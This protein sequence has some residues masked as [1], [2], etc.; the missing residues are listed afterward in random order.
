MDL[1]RGMFVGDY[2]LLERAGAGGFS[3]VWKA[4]RPDDPAL[5]AIKIPLVESFVEHLRR[6]ADLAGR[7]RHPRVVEILRVELAHDPPHLVMPWIDGRT[8]A[9]PESAPPP[10]G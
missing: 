7:L 1:A 3:I 10:R 8:L 4:K 6:E 2:E 9:L 5:Y